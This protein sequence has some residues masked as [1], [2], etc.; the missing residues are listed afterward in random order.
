MSEN[1]KAGNFL[2]AIKK[3]SEN[4][5]KNAVAELEAKKA[6]ELK[7]AEKRALSDAD[8]MVKKKLSE[9]KSKITSEYAVKNLEAQGEVFKKRDAMVKEIF[10][11]AEKKLAE[12]TLGEEYGAK[13]ISY[14]KEIADTFGDNE[15]VIYLSKNDMKYADEIKSLFN[16]SVEIKEDIKIRIGGLRGFCENLKLVADNTLDS[17]LEAQKQWFVEN[18]D[19]RIN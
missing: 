17:K 2:N 4:E 6:E 11:R 16:S 3:Y 8:K 15:Y 5:R 13:L 12:Y 7:K 19:L 18:A 14:A 10:E 1:N 9:A